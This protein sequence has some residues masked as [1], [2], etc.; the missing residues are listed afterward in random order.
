MTWKPTL[1]WEPTD[2]D[3]AWQ[4]NVLTLLKDGAVWGT[5]FGIFKVNKSD[6]T[7]ELTQ[8]DPDHECNQRILIV[9][10]RLGYKF[11]TPKKHPWE[12]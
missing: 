8:G 12:K 9:F 7:V 5:S 10:A 1:K 11:A 4:R 3:I 6:K 2:S